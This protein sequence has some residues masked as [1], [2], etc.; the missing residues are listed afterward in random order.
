MRRLAAW[1][2]LTVSLL[3]PAG[4]APAADLRTERLAA[5][6][7]LWA[8]AKYFH[9]ALARPEI[10][11]D[12]ALLTALPH[13][14]SARSREE[15]AD[16]V[17]AMLAALQDPATRVAQPK[18][19]PDASHR[20]RAELNS[21][22]VLVITLRSFPASS[23]DGEFLAE[24]RRAAGQIPSARGVVFDLREQSAC[25]DWDPSAAA[26]WFIAAGLNQRL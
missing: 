12:Q 1:V 19:A 3:G 16:A 24:L 17:S 9:P 4:G 7:K 22:G 21:D 5:L 6:G 15:Y 18:P 14:A 25:L 26:R 11:W 8:A 20:P 13:A 2:A 23:G 10:D